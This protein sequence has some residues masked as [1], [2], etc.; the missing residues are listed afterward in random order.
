[1]G[2]ERSS[3]VKARSGGMGTGAGLWYGVA[4]GRSR[5]KPCCEVRALWAAGHMAMQAAGGV[6]WACVTSWPGVGRCAAIW[7]D[8]GKGETEVVTV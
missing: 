5:M 3:V 1:M 4:E 7:T 2:D 6:G 8:I